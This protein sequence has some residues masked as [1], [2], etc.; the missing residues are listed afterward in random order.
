MDV[1]GWMGFPFPYQSQTPDQPV[2]LFSHLPWRFRKRSYLQLFLE[3][4]SMEPKIAVVAIQGFS[5]NFEARTAVHEVSQKLFEGL[6]RLTDVV[7]ETA[8]SERTHIGKDGDWFLLHRFLTPP[9]TCSVWSPDQHSPVSK[10]IQLLCD[11]TERALEARTLDPLQEDGALSR[12]ETA[13]NALRA[14]GAD[15]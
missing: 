8:S 6:A 15:V 9:T 10:T 5:Q 3:G 2:L 12:I 4:Q 13:V 7:F 1:A 11:L 14:H